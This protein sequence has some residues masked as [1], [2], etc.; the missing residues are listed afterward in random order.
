MREFYATKRK[1]S[2]FLQ[3]GCEIFVTW[4]PA[5]S[6]NEFINIIFFVLHMMESKIF[7]CVSTKDC[8]WS[9]T[10]SNEEEESNSTGLLPNAD[11]GTHLS[12]KY[13]INIWDINGGSVSSSLRLL[14]VAVERVSFLLADACVQCRA[15][16]S[17]FKRVMTWQNV[18]VSFR[19]LLEIVTKELK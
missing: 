10:S 18:V 15:R 11:R 19:L 6:T 8:F 3:Y 16:I 13:F 14:P 2:E 7:H 12:T 5:S 9:Y 4:R 17:L 1:L